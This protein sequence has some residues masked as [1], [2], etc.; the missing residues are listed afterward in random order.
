MGVYKR[1]DIYYI[2]FV[3]PNGKRIRE[4]VGPLKREAQDLL[5]KRRL[6]IREGKYFDKKFVSTATMDEL[7]VKY[8]DWARTKRSFENYHKVY[9]EPAKTYFL[10]RQLTSITELEVE[11][12]RSS[13]IGTDTMFGRTRSASTI[14]HELAV[15]K[16]LFAKAVDWGMADKNP[17]ARVKKLPEPKGRVRFLTVEE[18]GRLLQSAT[19]H[20]HPILICALE[21]GMRRGEI[22]GL[23]W[24]DI[25][26]RS[27]ML[28]VR[29][30]KN[31]DPRHVPISQRL[32]GTLTA[33]PRRL[34]CEYVFSG[35]VSEM[36]QVGKTG[37]TFGAVRTSF[38]N[39]LKA[40]RIAEF[41]FHDLRHTAASH[42]AMAGVPMKTIGEILGHKASAMTER[43]AHLSPEHKLQAVEMLPDW[44]TPKDDCHKS[45]TK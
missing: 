32:R 34:G 28:Y 17:A 27:G 21:T 8:L 35:G 3:D 5:G 20:L 24:S 4:A 19:P 43:Y 10:G 7:I 44:G 1:G 38:R 18:A 40:A 45:V 37:K 41:R 31:G 15:L 25:D 29:E 6:A 12:F 42:M 11:E 22:L 33:L 23:K 2:D 26:L 9:A 30:T 36:R 13:R 14:N 16:S 39:A